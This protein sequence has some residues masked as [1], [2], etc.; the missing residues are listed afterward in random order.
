MR[1]LPVVLLLLPACYV[2]PKYKLPNGKRACGSDFVERQY[3]LA[4]KVDNGPGDGSFEYALAD[5]PLIAST[6]GNFDLKT[7]EFYWVN[8]YAADAVRESELA[9]GGGT[10]RRNGDL[11]LDY[12]LKANWKS[13]ESTEWAYRHTRV[14]CDETLRREAVADPDDVELVDFSWVNGGADFVRYFVEGPVAVEGVGRI[15]ADRS[16]NEVV[17]FEQGGVQVLWYTEGDG[18]GH[19]TRTFDDDNGLAKS[20]GSWE[21]WYDGTVAMDFTYNRPDILRQ[22]WEFSMDAAGEGGGT[23]STS[24]NTCEVSFTEGKCRLKNCTSETLEGKCTVPVTW[25]FF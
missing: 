20:V 13:G 17:N 10:I 21:R 3:D 15:A 6:K 19:Q 12:V 4:M 22:T 5:W 2:G 8:T 23:W 25:P 16:W 7:G 1:A 11:D 24:D 9:E 18:N 14:G